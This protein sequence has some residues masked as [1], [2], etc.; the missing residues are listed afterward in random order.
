M[1]IK[2]KSVQTHCER[3]SSSGQ[4]TSTTSRMT[5]NLQVWKLKFPN[6]FV[7]WSHVTMH[8]SIEGFHPSH[9][10][11]SKSNSHRLPQTWQL[12]LC[13]RWIFHRFNKGLKCVLDPKLLGPSFNI[14]PPIGK[15]MPIIQRKVW[16]YGGSM[17]QEF[18]LR[19][20]AYGTDTH[21][22]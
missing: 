21:R 17:K 8:V 13:N 7:F 22:G 9:H 16:I 15:A 19:F 12:Q 11:N 1:L 5:Y 4:W 2:K 14:N 10:L 6:V 3:H 20:M 18:L